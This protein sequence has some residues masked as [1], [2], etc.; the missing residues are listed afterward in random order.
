MEQRDDVRFPARIPVEFS[1]LGA[2]SH[3]RAGT[4]RDISEGGV[5]LVTDTPLTVGT[6]LRV[7]VEDSLLFGEVKY[8]CRWM[9]VHV[10]GLYI[11]RALFG[12]SDLSQL[13]RATLPDAPL[14]QALA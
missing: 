10:C 9:G 12:K 14:I 3:P 4:I 7:D 5:R 2:E 6:F 11:E 8:C 13:V 1:V